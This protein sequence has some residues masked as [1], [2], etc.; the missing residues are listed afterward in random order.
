M[1]KRILVA[2]DLSEAS[3]EALR[4][5]HAEAQSTG[6]ELA[7]CHV[8]SYPPGSSAR[9]PQRHANDAL[10]H[11]ELEREIREALAMQLATCLAGVTAE[12]FV[13][14][15]E[16]ESVAPGIVARAEAW[17]ADLIVVSSHGR[18]V[19]PRSS[20]GSV[21]ERVV[22]SAR[23]PVLVARPPAK[24]GVVLAATDFSDPAM[25]AIAAAS[26]EAR[27]RNARL[28]VLHAV[29]F[30]SLAITIEEIAR[31]L[32]HHGG[33]ASWNVDTEI[34]RCLE[35]KLRGALTHCGAHGETRVVDGVAAEGIV[36]SAA[37]LGAELVVVGTRGR[38]GIVR[39]ALG[40][41]ADK[42]VRDAGCSVL[43]VRL[44]GSAAPVHGAAAGA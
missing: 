1:T 44:G 9:I 30:G 29:A 4:Q 8:L 42:V 14:A 33:G 6:A 28:V 37:E 22:R 15:G 39:L 5:A 26:H 35:A 2:S 36:R 17:S 23:C 34:C 11:T 24:G 10:H 32:M 27:R 31:D 13:D 19:P 7:V 38:T 18:S 12:I 41:T 3:D 20:I 43:A 21:A 25:P 40:S 16:D